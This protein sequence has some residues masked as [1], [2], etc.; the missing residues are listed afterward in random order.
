[1]AG[2]LKVTV[3]SF[4]VRV[5]AHLGRGR[6]GLRSIVGS[7]LD[8]LGGSSMVASLIS[9]SLRDGAALLQCRRRD[10]GAVCDEGWR[11]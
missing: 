5:T 7:S 1:M 11:S 4:R 8:Q 2:E 9:C 10:G 3:H 6:S